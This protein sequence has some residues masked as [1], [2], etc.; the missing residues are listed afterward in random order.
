MAHSRAHTHHMVPFQSIEP[1]S[2]L[3]SIDHITNLIWNISNIALPQIVLTR[4]RIRIKLYSR[5]DT[6]Q[7]ITPEDPCIIPREINKNAEN[8]PF[9]HC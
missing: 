5:I 9:C 7:L 1:N 6:S 2:I 3:N 4:S 8:V